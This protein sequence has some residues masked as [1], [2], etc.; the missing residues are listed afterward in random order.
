MKKRGR[1]WVTSRDNFCVLRARGPWNKENLKR[2][3]KSLN[4]D[5]DTPKGC[6]WGSLAVLYGESLL[7]PDALTIFIQAHQHMVEN[8]LKCVAVVLSEVA[9]Q[10]LVKHQFS[11]L[12]QQC[13]IEYEFFDNERSALEW[14]EKQQIQ[15]NPAML[16]QHPKDKFW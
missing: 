4:S 11:G 14:L 9:V 3:L 2:F 5:M 10:P 6:E 7:T 13:G 16:L 15:I 12:Y 8:G 1:I